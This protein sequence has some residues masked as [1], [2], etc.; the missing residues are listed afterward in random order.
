MNDT[1][2]A[3]DIFL[4]SSREIEWVKQG[5]RRVSTECFNLLVRRS[6]DMETKFAIVVGRRFGTAVRRNRA[7]RMFR[8]LGR[9]VRGHFLPGYRF[10]VFPKR[11]CLAKQFAVLRAGWIQMLERCGLIHGGI[12]T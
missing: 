7:K 3:P 2:I 10:L 4:R 5:G 12:L 6:D 8:E 9:L 1:R 11:D